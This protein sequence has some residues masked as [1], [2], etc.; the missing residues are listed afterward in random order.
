MTDLRDIRDRLEVRNAACSGSVFDDVNLSD[1]AFTNVNL[2]N[3]RFENVNMTGV[4]IDNANLTGMRI[5]GI[6]VEDMLA[7][8]EVRA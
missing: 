5:R 3:V 8:Y 1:A 7:A 2:S 6:P 4:S